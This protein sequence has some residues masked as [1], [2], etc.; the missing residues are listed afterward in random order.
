MPSA[1][2]STSASISTPFSNLRHA[3]L[4]VLLDADAA[5]REMHAL[6]RHRLGQHRVQL[7]AMEDHVRRA[8]LL[9]DLSPSGALG[10]RAAVLPAA[11]M[12]ER[13]AERHLGAFLAKAEPDQEP[14]RVRARC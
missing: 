8:E 1:A 6:R 12:E 7:A 2:I 10:Q 5:M 14:R 3:W 9:L 13:R 11:L 4:A